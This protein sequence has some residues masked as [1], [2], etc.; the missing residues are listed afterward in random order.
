MIQPGH[1]EAR[2]RMFVF[3][4]LLQQISIVFKA[5]NNVD[6]EGRFSG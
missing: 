6:A 4:K 2:H 1:I 3:A 5:G